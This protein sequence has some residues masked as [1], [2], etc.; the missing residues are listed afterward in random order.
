VK[1]FG[2]DSNLNAVSYCIRKYGP[3]FSTGAVENIPFKNKSQYMVTSKDVLEHLPDFKQGLEEIFRVANKW[4]ILNFFHG[5]S[6]GDAKIVPHPDGYYLN[7][8]SRE[9]VTNFCVAQGAIG[10]EEHNI[11]SLAGNETILVCEV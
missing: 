2:I 9:E 5:L 6:D 11:P 3:F 7:T 1:Y 10:I 8:Y 4:V